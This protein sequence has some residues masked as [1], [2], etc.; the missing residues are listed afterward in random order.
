MDQVVKDGAF[1]SRIRTRLPHG[2]LE[3]HDSA[4]GLYI[5]WPRGVV[6]RSQGR[7]ICEPFAGLKKQWKQERDACRMH[8]VVQSAELL[9]GLHSGFE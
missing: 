7:P 6:P 2:E 9:T 1:T 8:E 5:E 3:L 4:V